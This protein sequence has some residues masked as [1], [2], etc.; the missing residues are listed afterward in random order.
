MCIPGLPNRIVQRGNNR[1]AAFYHSDDR[2]RYLE[3]LSEAKERHDVAIHAYVLMT[4]HVHLLM[5]PVTENGLSLTMQSLGRKYVAYINKTYR[6]TGTLW[7]GRFKCS[8]IDT[9]RYC[10]ACYRYFDLNPVRAGMVGRA[11]EYR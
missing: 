2:A 3:I 4:N 8:L 5:T 11:G 6:R 9:D 1:H 10:L 7:E